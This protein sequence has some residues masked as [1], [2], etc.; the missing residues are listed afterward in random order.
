MEMAKPVLVKKNSPH[1][2]EIRISVPQE[3]SLKF[4]QVFLYIIAKIGAKSNVG[5]TVLCKLLY[6]IDFNYYE[7]YEEQ[8]M[9]LVYVKDQFGP[10]P[11]RF[12][13]LVK[14]MAEDKRLEIVKTKY[15]DKDQTK[16][17]PIAR[18]DL[19]L[20]TAREI[21]HIDD[22]LDKYSDKTASELSDI[23]HKDIP[24]IVAKEK[25]PISYESVFY[26]N[27]TSV[28]TYSD[29]VQ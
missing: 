16:Y 10:R 28:R 1:K 8:L 22:V 29:G 3:N 27:E 20:L 19:N 23:S 25:E 26:R 6:F 12:K 7:L 9:G 17:R 18:P 13:E 24:W 4:E 11:P 15:H 2:D 5:K 21:K 14:K